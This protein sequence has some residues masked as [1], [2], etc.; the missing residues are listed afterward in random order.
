VPPTILSAY[1]ALPSPT[2]P[3][4]AEIDELTGAYAT[5]SPQKLFPRARRLLNTIAR[6]LREPMMDGRRRWLLVDASEVAA[7]AGW[8]AL[9]SGHPGD[10]DAYFTQALKLAI[11]SGV[12]QARGCALVSMSVLHDPFVGDGDAATGLALLQAAE[13]LLGAGCPTA[14]TIVISQADFSAALNH[15]D[16][17]MSLLERADRIRLADDGQG[18][19]SLRGCYAGY[20]E[21]RLAGWSARILAHLKRTDEALAALGRSLAAPHV[22][23]RS[24]T[25][26]LGDVALA[27]T[28]GG[29]PEPACQAATRSLVVS[30]T[31]G[32]TVGVDRVRRVRDMMPREWTPLAC[33]RELDERL[34]ILPDPGHHQRG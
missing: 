33:V 28:K 15:H 18:F 26:L 16:E 14:K 31:V 24:S 1:V 19:Y 12:D 17:A 9:F 13:P 23:M 4:R 25:V 11:Q 27:H 21:L 29:N 32:Y 3:L 22:N 34:R 7:V 6:T 8:M 5:S 10:A 20:D 30:K 2:D